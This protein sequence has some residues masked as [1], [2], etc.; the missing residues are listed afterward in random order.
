M[1]IF[2]NICFVIVNI[3]SPLYA[4]NMASGQPQI[5]RKG[6]NPFNQIEGTQFIDGAVLPYM[7]RTVDVINKLK[8][9]DYN[10]RDLAI[11]DIIFSYE[12]LD[13][14][15]VLHIWATSSLGVSSAGAHIYFDLLTN[16]VKEYRI[17]EVSREDA[18]TSD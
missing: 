8:P 6:S 17:V 10:G 14:G 12:Y 4:Q 5:L 2:I 3:F 16:D 18:L 9:E 7:K 1:K 15:K 13:T 11:S